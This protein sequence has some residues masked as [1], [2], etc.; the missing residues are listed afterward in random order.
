MTDHFLELADAFDGAAEATKHANTDERAGDW[1]AA[2][3]GVMQH[4]V[5]GEDAPTPAAA[6]PTRRA[7]TYAEAWMFGLVE[8]AAFRSHVR[9]DVNGAE[10]LLDSGQI[11][12]SRRYLAR[13][14]NWSEKAVRV[15]VGK[16]IL[17]GMVSVT[18]GPGTP[19]NRGQGKG[20]GSNVLT[21]CNYGK[22]QPSGKAKGQ[23]KG[24]PPPHSGATIRN[25]K[26]KQPPYPQ[27][28]P[29]QIF[30]DRKREKRQPTAQSHDDVCQLPPSENREALAKLDS[31]QPGAPGRMARKAIADNH[32]RWPVSVLGELSAGNVFLSY[33]THAERERW[34]GL[35][36]DHAEGTGEFAN[37]VRF[38]PRARPDF[39][40]A[41]L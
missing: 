40:G 23:G 36:K 1:F 25:N 29:G 3:R 31:V 34:L 26:L 38:A 17:D 32:G 30:D 20:Q 14:F 11:L 19:P 35:A 41:P 39:A 9:R 4:P 16:L 27:R 21:L 24:Q 8:S 12:A 6:D 13:K 37:V 7:W 18:K 28:G 33:L 15:F 5:I 2:G 22:F 10:R